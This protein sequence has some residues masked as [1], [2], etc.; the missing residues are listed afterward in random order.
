MKNMIR[1]AL[2]FAA[3]AALSACGGGGGGS[4][5]G[6]QYFTHE[7]LAKEFVR[8]VN[9]DVAGYDLTLVKTNTQQYD[10]IV[11]YD[12]DYGTYDAYWLGAYNPGEDLYNYLAVN[13]NYFYFD[14]IPE[15]GNTYQDYYTGTIFEKTEGSSK[16]LSQ[17]KA[18]REQLAIN[19]TADSM[20]ATYGMSEEK[21]NDVASFAYKMKTATPGTYNIKDYDSFAKDLTGSS[22]TE[23]QNDLKSGKTESLQSRIEKAGEITGMGTEGTDKLIKDMFLNN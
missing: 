6:G 8:R 15:A 13:Q 11:V 1:A 17:M 5:T 9:I 19:K 4:S 3:V 21:A 22:I 7:E 14:L 18:L 16:N 12:N 2:A 23:F 20:R 10:Y